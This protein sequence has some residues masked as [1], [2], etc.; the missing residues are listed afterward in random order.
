M[1]AVSPRAG[2]SLIE[3]VLTLVIAGVLALLAV[4]RAQDLVLRE[5][6][7]AARRQVT[8]HLS[9]ARATAVQRGCSAV[10]HLNDEAGTVWLT[11]CPLA[12]GSVAAIDTVGGV[13]NVLERFGVAFTA[14][15]DSVLYTPQG[16]AFGGSSITLTF[17][18]AE[19]S[20]AL[21][22]TPVGRAVW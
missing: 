3:L 22:V 16:V 20:A 21:E 13:D 15:G 8:T 9:R 11:A 10:L 5:S 17:S 2:F 4:P 1:I 19:H 12:G 7:R 14:D 6:V 18:R